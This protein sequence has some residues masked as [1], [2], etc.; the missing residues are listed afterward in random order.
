MRARRATCLWA[1]FT[2][3]DAHSTLIGV[4]R[5]C[6]CRDVTW[7][8]VVRTKS[9]KLPYP[10]LV[11]MHLQAHPTPSAAHDTRSSSEFLYH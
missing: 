7:E 1:F 4:H 8:T 3:R 5:R 11:K 2:I 9:E 6:V 10:I